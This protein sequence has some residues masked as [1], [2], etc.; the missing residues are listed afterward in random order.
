V[1]ERWVVSRCFA[2]GLLLCTACGASRPS[3]PAAPPK[4]VKDEVAGCWRD[5]EQGIVFCLEDQG[6]VLLL[7]DGKWDRV[8]VDWADVTPTR[9]SGRTRT[10][11]PLWLSVRFEAGALVMDDGESE[12][13]LARPSSD[14][15]ARLAG[16]V[17]RLPKLDQVCDRAEK[18]RASAGHVL[19]GRLDRKD[20]EL[21]T[22]RACVGYLNAVATVLR[23]AA[24]P[25][26]P[27]CGE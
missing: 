1:I 26:P 24:Q 18:C 22:A 4:P 3:E 8:V 14:E 6:Y 7:P 17:S 5:A 19:G 11:R 16:R 23:E 21:S 25:I 15:Q 2:L 20:Q 9:R 12:T 10:P 27:E 13:R